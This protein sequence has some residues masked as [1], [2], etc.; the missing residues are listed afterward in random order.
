[1]IFVAIG[2][3]VLGCLVGW[4]IRQAW[5]IDLQIVFDDGS[6]IEGYI[7]RGYTLPD[8]DEE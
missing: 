7:K 5:L 3:F 6:M 4:A 1:M 2:V 8:E